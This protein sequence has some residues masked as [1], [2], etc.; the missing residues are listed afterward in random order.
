MTI[1]SMHGPDGICNSDRHVA[2]RS[3]RLHG[4]AVVRVGMEYHLLFR[5]QRGSERHCLVIIRENGEAAVRN[6]WTPY[7]V[8]PDLEAARVFCE[9]LYCETIF[10]EASTSGA[11]AAWPME[12]ARGDRP[13]GTLCTLLQ[14]TRLS[15]GLH[16]CISTCGTSEASLHAVLAC[17]V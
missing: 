15:D 14:R 1:L 13:L 11:A 17:L 9:R 12:A 16:S 4:L 10:L 5:F 2:P 8:E 7:P 6:S 3:E